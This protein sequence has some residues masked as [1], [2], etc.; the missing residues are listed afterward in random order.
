MLFL[1]VKMQSVGFT[2]KKETTKR[3]LSVNDMSPIRKDRR[4]QKW[5]PEPKM[6]L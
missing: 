5:C 4:E 2:P 1:S 3:Y 6:V